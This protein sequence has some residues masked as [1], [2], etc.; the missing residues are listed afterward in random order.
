MVGRVP[1]I[2]ASLW[3]LTDA[4]RRAAL[5]DG[6]GTMTPATLLTIV[7]LTA[8]ALFLVGGVAGL[9]R[10]TQRNSPAEDSEDA[11]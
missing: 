9:V 5:A 8:G 4:E 2:T 10:R 7:L 3:F 11:E 1:R 6:V